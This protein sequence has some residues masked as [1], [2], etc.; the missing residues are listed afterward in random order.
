[1]NTKA[2]LAAI[3]LMTGNSSAAIFIMNVSG[4]INSLQVRNV[5]GFPTDVSDGSAFT[6][7]FSY[8]LDLW[9]WREFGNSFVMDR[10]AGTINGG[11]WYSGM[12]FTLNAGS[13]Q[14]I[15]DGTD[16][17]YVRQFLEV[18]DDRGGAFG[19]AQDSLFTYLGIIDEASPAAYP[20]YLGA[21]DLQLIFS[22]NVDFDFVATHGPRIEPMKDDT[23]G[24]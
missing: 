22:D 4:T 24:A 13:S 3:A 17:T 7:S 20:F 10:I 14:W 11:M 8:D 6:A 19:S 2:T 23:G 16:F 5:D 18:S 21:V 12:E 1:M 9:E 15:L